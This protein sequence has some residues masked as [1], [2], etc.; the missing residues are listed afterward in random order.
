MIVIER[1]AYL[2]MLGHC[3]SLYP[4]EACGFLAGANGRLSAVYLVENVLHSPVRFEMHPQ[5][6][7]EAMLDSEEKGLPDLVIYHSHPQGPPRPSPTDLRLAYYPDWPQLI[8]S[9]ESRHAPVVRAFS[10]TATAVSERK[11]YLE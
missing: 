1:T 7:L 11:W 3:Q 4:Q 2:T 10:I 6:Q 5:Q 8:V 9:L